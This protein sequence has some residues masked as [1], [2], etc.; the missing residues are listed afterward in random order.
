[1]GDACALQRVL[2]N[3]TGQVLGLQ[4]ETLDPPSPQ[5]ASSVLSYESRDQ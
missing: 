5:A 4:E 1:M 3:L 2:G